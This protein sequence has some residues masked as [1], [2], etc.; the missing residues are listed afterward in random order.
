[1]QKIYLCAIKN[2]IEL[3]EELNELMTYIQFLI[4]TPPNY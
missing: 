3:R 2:K 4:F 1:M